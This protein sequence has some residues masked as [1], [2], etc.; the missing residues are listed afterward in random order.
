[1][2]E[3][4][5]AKLLLEFGT[6]LF[7][8]LLLGAVFE[9]LGLPSVVGYLVAGIALGPQG[10]NL[11]SDSDVITLMSEL[12]II[13]LL[14]YTGLEISFKRFKEAGFYALFLSPVKSGIGFALGYL[15]ALLL[16]LDRTGAF[17]VGASL[18]VSSTAIISQI[19]AE[20]HWERMLEAQISLAMLILEDIF[21]VF[22][23]AYLLGAAGSGI[24]VGKMLFHTFLIVFLLFSVGAYVF[25]KIFT[26]LGRFEKRER[27]S[28]YALGLLALFSFGVSLFGMSPILG[29]F[30]A[31]LA[32]AESVYA[33]RL[34]Q[35]LSTF[36]NIFVLV[37]FTALGLK[38]RIAFSWMAMWICLL[39]LF[40]V[41]VQR[42]VLLFFSP[43]LGIEPRRAARLAI[44]MLP[45]GEFALFFSAVGQDIGVP[46]SPDIMGGMFVAI[47]FT[48]ALAGWLLRDEE[49]VEA[50]IAKIVPSWLSRRFTPFG[51]ASEKAMRY[52]GGD[53]FGQF[54]DARM[55][56]LVVSLITAIFLFYFV[57]YY[58]TEVGKASLLAFLV[59]YGVAAPVVAYFLVEAKRIVDE[60]LTTFY[61]FAKRRRPVGHS[62]L[63]T[64][65]FALG[66]GILL[67][68]IGNA[69][70]VLTFLLMSF[71]LLSY[72]VALVVYGV[73]R[74][75]VFRAWH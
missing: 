13:L 55:R 17:I 37:F 12:G 33:R 52:V 25:T 11:V 28:I 74:L 48:T 42:L 36:R 57:G 26:F 32:L 19:I 29:A 5:S 61:K 31:G 24:S 10:L 45:L 41:L 1:M 73:L 3:S 16:G 40:V 69:L 47:L 2:A 58:V 70:S 60:F 71:L 8:S 59:G 15:G 27:F 66:L 30:F 35:E 18:A 46:H 64:G 38:Y 34:S 23:I 68:F 9:H 14:F 62:S 53:V 49:R 7:V 43:L 44:L 51:A 22:F 50:V 54:M 4:A 39:A 20:R 67:Y 63:L 75:T 6:V 72:G 65:F 21:S 56:R